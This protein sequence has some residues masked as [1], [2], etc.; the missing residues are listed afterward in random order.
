MTT[1][2]LASST[3]FA[4]SAGINAGA[5]DSRAVTAYPFGAVLAGSALAGARAIRGARARGF[6]D[7]FFARMHIDKPLLSIGNVVTNAVQTVRIWNAH[8]DA[9]ETLATIGAISADGVTFSG[10]SLPAAFLPNQEI[11]WTYTITPQGPSVLDAIATYTFSD[12]EMVALEIR[13]TRLVAWTQP[14][15]WSDPV[16]ETLEYKTDVLIAWSGVEQRRALRIA[17]RRTFQFGATLEGQSRRVI[18]AALFAWSSRVWALPIWPDGQRLG[19]ALPAGSSSIA[20]DTVNR[21]FAVGNWAII[22]QDAARYEIVTIAAIASGS[23]TLSTSTVG[24]WAA[25]ARL[26]PVRSAMLAAYP[27]IARASGQLATVQPSFLIVEP[28]DWPP[29]TGLATYRGFPVLEDSPDSS[30][31]DRA[32]YDRQA[33]T[34]DNDTGAIAIDDTANVGFPMNTHNWFLNG[35]TARAKFRALLYLLK[36]R[37]GEIW[38]PSYQSDLKLA[39]NVSSG[40]STIDVE[41]LRFGLFLLGARNRQDIRIELTNGSVWYRRVTAAFG[42]DPNTERLTLDSALPT[43]FTMAAVRRISFMALSRL[44]TDAIAINHLAA[45]DGLAVASAQFRAL[46][47]N[48]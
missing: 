25:G 4:A 31:N 32:G 37:W 6:G 24:S 46:N 20:C 12:G 44:A 33:V 2:T 48:V 16:V 9:S 34:I 38:L 28:C 30:Q 22:I 40:A 10:P 36:G 11:S 39:A 3:I 43:A 15:D 18:E 23:L 1:G 42:L 26:Y 5:Y 29:A 35:R 21:D 27:D 13:G 45:A 17:P 19:A 7:D 8:L 41:V 14:P 47:R